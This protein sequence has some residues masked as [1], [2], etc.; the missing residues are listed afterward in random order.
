MTEVNIRYSTDEKDNIY[1]PITHMEAV[2]GFNIL[3]FEDITNIKEDLDN[4]WD[5]SNNTSSQLSSLQNKL[6]SLETT[7]NTMVKD[8]GWMN[9][10]LLNNAI[11]YSSTSTP[12]ARMITFNG[13][14]FISLKGAV[15]GLKSNNIDIGKL[16]N[17]ISVMLTNDISFAQNIAVSGGT[18]Q[19]TRMGLNSNGTLKIEN[20]TLDTITETQWFPID[21]TIMI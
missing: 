8:T 4:V 12:Q 19:F 1:Y 5:Q 21:T 7:I 16:P 9:I 15:K 18:A 17:E 11:P 6:S 20:T 14:T 2:E 13:V 3:E 10:I